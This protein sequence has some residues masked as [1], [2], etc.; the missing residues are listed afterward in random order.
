LVDL[1][2]DAEVGEM[3]S[4]GIV[5][6][7]EAE[8]IITKGKCVYL[9]ADMK[10][11]QC[12]ALTQHAIGVALK[13]VAIGEFCPVCVRG[14]VKVTC[15]GD[16]TRGGVVQTDANGNVVVV[17]AAAAVGDVVDR[18]SR[19]LGKALQTFT[20]ATSDTGLIYVDHA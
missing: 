17:V 10:V 9:S 11:S 7:F 14:V 1:W 3:I 12:T 15:G 16:I 20:G 18:I 19:T 8:T 2:S 4:D 6:S 5:L 13:T